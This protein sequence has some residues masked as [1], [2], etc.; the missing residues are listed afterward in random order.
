[1]SK[2]MKKCSKCGVEKPLTDYG[3]NTSS[4]DG[5]RPNCKDCNKSI[6]SD[7]IDYLNMYDGESHGGFVASLYKSNQLN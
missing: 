1:M 6:L 2:I 7:L 3:K 4:K 5:L